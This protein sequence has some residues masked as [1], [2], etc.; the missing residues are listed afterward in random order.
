MLNPLN[1]RVTVWPIS[2]SA[3]HRR[4]HT[5]TLTHSHIH[6]LSH[7]FG[8]PPR[9]V[10]A[11]TVSLLL[12]LYP[13][14]RAA[15]WQVGLREE[16]G[17]GKCFSCR[18]RFL[19]LTKKLTLGAAYCVRCLGNNSTLKGFPSG[20]KRAFQNI[21]N[22]S[23]EWSWQIRHASPFIVAQSQYYL[24]IPIKSCLYP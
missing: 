9:P 8:R 11:S 10:I 22:F 5:H 1:H 19:V 18:L 16:G 17:T 4:A 14:A 15:S 12:Y 21:N 20:R 7:A 13:G 24:K 3:D 6:A 23:L 2:A